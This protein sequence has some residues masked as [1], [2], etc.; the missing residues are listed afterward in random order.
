MYWLEHIVSAGAVISLCTCLYAS[1][2]PMP[3]IVYSMASD[4]LIFKFLASI[5]PKLK[6]PFVASIT[7]GLISG[8]L[9]SIFNLEELVDM[10]SIGTLMAFSL[11]SMCVLMLRYMPTSSS[12]PSQTT[13]SEADENMKKVATATNTNETLIFGE[14]SFFTSLFCPSFKMPNARSCRLVNCLCLLSSKKRLKAL[15]R[16][17]LNFNAHLLYQKTFFPKNFFSGKIYLRSKRK[18][19]INVQSS[20]SE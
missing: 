7:A 11:V 3:R 20:P 12:P 13:A 16:Y 19:Y 4:G 8:L 14:D 9:A 5:M 10:M 1:M 17:L 15:N 2:F 6:T 18:S